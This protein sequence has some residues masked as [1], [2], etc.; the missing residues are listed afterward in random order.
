MIQATNN[1][2]AISCLSL[3][4]KNFFHFHKKI[5]AKGQKRLLLI[6]TRR[7]AT[8]VPQPLNTLSKL[9]SSNS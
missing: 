4:Q 5:K 3:T 2:A 8:K 7:L 9:E 1:K 6:P